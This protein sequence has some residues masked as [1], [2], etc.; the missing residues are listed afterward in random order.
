MGSDP[1]PFFANH[2]L[3]FSERQCLLNL[4]RL[5]LFQAG[6]FSSDFRLIDDKNILN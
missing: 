2:I 6:K 3:R 5:N 4:K 1:A